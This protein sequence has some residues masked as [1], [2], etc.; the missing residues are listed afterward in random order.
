MRAQCLLA[1]NHPFAAVRAADLAAELSPCW[2][3]AHLTLARCQRELGEVAL[4]VASYSAAV[5]L[6]PHCREC[7]AE[8]SE[9]KELLA[10]L[11]SIHADRTRG[12]SGLSP[13]E[14]EAATCALHL[15]SRASVT[16][17]EPDADLTR[18][19]SP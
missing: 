1:L 16:G 3:V 19:Q 9:A 15:Q 8:L 11:E 4:A 7:A 13:E 17:A 2:A 14:R 6:D 18:K 12:L 5:D 10:R